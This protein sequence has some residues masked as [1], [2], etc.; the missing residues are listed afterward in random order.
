MAMTTLAGWGNYPR[1]ECDLRKPT[2]RKATATEVENSRS[3]IARGL[4]R[5]YGDPAVSERGVV[6]DCTGL[7]RYLDFDEASGLLTCEAGTSLEALLR[8]FGPRGFLPMITPGTKFVTVGGCIANDVHGKA[9]HIDG[10]FSRCTESFRILLASGEVVNASRTEHA[11]LFWA[12]FGGMGLLGVILDATIRLRRVETTYFRQQAVS[13][14]HLDALL[15]ALDEYHHLPYSVAWVDSLATG[16][17]LGRGV[18]TVGEHALMDDL[19]P[20][21]QRAPLAVSDPSPL[22][23]PFE[24]PS[25]A[26]NAGT[27][28]ILNFV[29]DQVQRHGAAIAHYEKFFYPLDFVGEW[30]RGYGKKGFTQYQFVIPMEDGRR[31]IRTLLETIASSGQ[32]PFLNV[33]KR[34][35]PEEAETSLSFPFEG[36]T[37]AIDF[38]VRRGLEDLLKK[39]DERVVQMG[40]RI[41]LGKDA[42]VDAAMLARMY[43]RLDRWREVKARYDP[44]GRF[45]SSLSRRV[46]LGIRPA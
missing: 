46:G 9:H 38:P 33:L 39:L 10:C 19:S 40:G 37:F 2:S 6:L 41:Y 8:D 32:A 21:R 36:Y 3:A 4:G 45:A 18:L 28:R 30:N 14:P 25:G 44:N 29:L 17:R 1:V 35:G 24:M 7:D 27:I 15:D 31:N 42:F 20:A 11:D 26:L 34:F 22:V 23:L 16:R 13:V 43:P 12:N 5:S